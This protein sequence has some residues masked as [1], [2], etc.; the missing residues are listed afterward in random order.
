MAYSEVARHLG[1]GHMRGDNLDGAL[2]LFQEALALAE[3]SHIR[4]F[5]PFAYLSI[6]EVFHMRMIAAELDRL[7]QTTA[8]PSE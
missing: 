6:G 7:R 8:D 2:R 4:L 5:L 1:F 3:K